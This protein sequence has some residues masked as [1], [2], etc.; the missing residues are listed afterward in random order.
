MCM[1]EYWRY[2]VFRSRRAESR[3]A[4]LARH[5]QFITRNIRARVSNQNS[6]RCPCD[7]P[8]IF[9][10]KVSRKIYD[11]RPAYMCAVAFKTPDEML[12]LNTLAAVNHGSAHKGNRVVYESPVRSWKRE[13]VESRKKPRQGINR[14]LHLSQSHSSFSLV[15]FSSRAAFERFEIKP[16]RVRFVRVL[17]RSGGEKGTRFKKY[18]QLYRAAK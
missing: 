16:V 18:M 17:C 4:A 14:R 9:I 13:R 3:F 15:R 2:R 5:A 10:C 8:N 12:A 11:W 6:G 1:R 7:I